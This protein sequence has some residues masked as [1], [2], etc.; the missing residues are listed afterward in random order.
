MTLWG[1]GGGGGGGA[2][3]GQRFQILFLSQNCV[4]AVKGK[5]ESLQ[6]VRAHSLK[7]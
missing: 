2:C 5:V 3:R 1:G 7:F 4:H 6:S